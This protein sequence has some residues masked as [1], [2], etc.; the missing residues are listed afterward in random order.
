MD[1]GPTIKAGLAHLP[2]SLCALLTPFAWLAQ[3]ILVPPKV[4]LEPVIHVLSVS[5]PS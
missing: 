3:P 1:E 2:P 5:D 4:P